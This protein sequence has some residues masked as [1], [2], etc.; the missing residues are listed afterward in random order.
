MLL[1][2]Q[3]LRCEKRQGEGECA[4]LGIITRETRSIQS[5]CGRGRLTDDEGHKGQEG[6]VFDEHLESVTAE[7]KCESAEELMGT[8]LG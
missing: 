3:V 8:D 5:A 6:S 1:T 2:R 7:V 4:S